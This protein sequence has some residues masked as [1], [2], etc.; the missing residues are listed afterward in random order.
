MSDS[1]Q[2]TADSVEERGAVLAFKGL[3]ILIVVLVEGLTRIEI[4]C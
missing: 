2:P 3:L 4:L 1:R